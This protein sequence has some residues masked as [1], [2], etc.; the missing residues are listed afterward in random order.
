V[1]HP[2]EARIEL[3]YFNNTGKT[4]CLDDDDWP[5]LAG[6]LNQMRGVFLVVGTE[7]FPI[8]FFNTGYCPGGCVRRVKPGETISGSIPYQD[9]ELPE[10]LR[11]EPKT[12][13]FFP[14]AFVC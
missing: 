10:R 6:K 7:R 4:L 2:E 12:L 9:F 8:E 11:Y 3:V 5:N 1:D 14:E 13:E